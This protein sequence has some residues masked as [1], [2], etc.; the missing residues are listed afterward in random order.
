MIGAG[1]GGII[2]A[3]RAAQLGAQALLLEKT[4][5]IGTK[6]LIS[7]GGKCNVA[8]DGPLEDVIRA[9]RPNEAQFI[10]PACYRF[11]NKTIMGLFTD[12]GCEL[13]TRPDGRVFPKSATAKDVVAILT[14][15]LREAGVDVRLNVAVSEIVTEGGAI[16]GVRLSKTN[17]LSKSATE[18]GFGAQALLRQA[19]T[20]ESDFGRDWQGEDWLPCNR[21]VLATGGSSYPNSGTTGD[22]WVWARKLGHRI[23]RLRAALAP[24]YFQAPDA[25]LSGV[26]VRGGVLYARSEGR[27]FARADG[28]V[29]FTHKGISG[30]ATLRISRS[31]AEQMESAPVDMEIDLLPAHEFEEIASELRNRDPR[32]QVSSY[33]DDL[34]PERLRSRILQAAQLDPT[35]THAKLEKKILNRFAS[36]LKRWPVGSVKSVPLE[37]GEVVAG[38]VALDEVDPKTMQSKLVKGLYLCGEVL[39]IAGQVGGYNLQAAFATGFV[40]GESA[41]KY[42]L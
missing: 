41:S 15:Y 18:G 28:D 2:A 5:R 12:R 34:V 4:P 9:F 29:L 8:H 7:G 19:M 1:A 17:L 42:V 20:T 33:L 3:W 13:Y 16:S 6:I 37:K 31:V 32:K 10:R 35:T 25:E 39:D 40:A 36:T 23:E 30:P 26:A 38:G 22:G 11:P 21:V 27:Q 24:I 14:D